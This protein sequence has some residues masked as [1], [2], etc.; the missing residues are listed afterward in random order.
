M[1]RVLANVFVFVFVFVC[2][3]FFALALVINHGIFFFFL[4][5]CIFNCMTKSVDEGTT[6]ADL[7]LSE[8]QRMNTVQKISDNYFEELLS[9]AETSAH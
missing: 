2:R 9:F 5:S 7:P 4:C 1:S 6:W 3:F 8:D